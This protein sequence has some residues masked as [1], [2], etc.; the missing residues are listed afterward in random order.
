MK[1]LL[2]IT[3]FFSGSVFAM[4]IPFGAHSVNGVHS[5]AS[6]G[7]KLV[8]VVYRG[9]V[10]NNQPVFASRIATIPPA[11]MRSLLL[12]R[13][14][15]TFFNPWLSA[16]LL[17][18]GYA[19]NSLSTQ[20]EQPGT[21]DPNLAPDGYGYF[22]NSGSGFYSQT[23]S[24]A[25]A[26]SVAWAGA[27]F[28]INGNFCERLYGGNVVESQEITLVPSTV[29]D[30]PY[31]YPDSPATPDQLNNFLNGLTAAQLLK[32]FINP[33]TFKPDD[34][35]E[36][37]TIGDEITSDYTADNDTLP[38]GSPD[39]T[40]SPTTDY[41]TGDTGTE[42]ISD[43]PPEPLVSSAT[44]EEQPDLCELNPGILACQQMGNE[45]STE[46]I[47][48]ETPSYSFV[49]E[50]LT[51]NAS[52]PAPANLGLSSGSISMSYQPLCDLAIAINPVFIIICTL[53]GLYIVVGAART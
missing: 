10:L 12:K 36:I 51:S 45:L 46:T 44:A 8:S 23:K 27:E 35:P 47:P 13:A 16:A 14:A 32:L 37:T 20:I 15:S 39:L 30:G 53:A 43:V 3:L 21:T 22:V 42:S 49:A 7:N 19:Y 34:I 48:V 50:N 31:Q 4:E 25:C 11:G 24:G 26:L 29:S 33:L 41:S 18:G 9:R 1:I 2:I 28:N 6:T 40:T 38:D 5:Q 17:V 52:C